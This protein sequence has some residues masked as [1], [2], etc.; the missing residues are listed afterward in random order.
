MKENQ[1]EWLCVCICVLL[2]DI[3]YI[4]LGMY[5]IFPFC[6]WVWVDKC[7]NST[8]FS[9]LYSVAFSIYFR[10][11]IHVCCFP[12]TYIYSVFAAFCVALTL[13]FALSL[14]LPCYLSF[15]FAQIVFTSTHT[16]AKTYHRHLMLLTQQGDRN[17]DGFDF[18]K[19][20]HGHVSVCNDTLHAVGFPDFRFNKPETRKN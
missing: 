13:Y 14:S 3:E 6:V 11:C 5:R 15:I 17:S 1:K 19:F 9:F 18:I 7:E 20:L 12:N 2:F 10:V 16:F 4:F 8:S